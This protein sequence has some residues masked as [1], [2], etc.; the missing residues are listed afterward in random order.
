MLVYQENEDSVDPS[1]QPR[2]AFISS[3]PALADDYPVLVSAGNLLFS[4]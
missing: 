1:G 4:F 2:P 3:I